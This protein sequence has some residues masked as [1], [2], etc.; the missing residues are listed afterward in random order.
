MMLAVVIDM[1]L[2]PEWIPLFEQAGW[3][4]IHWSAV[5]DPAADDK[6]IMAWAAANKHVIFTHDLDFSTALALT[7]A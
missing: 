6:V 5:G 1:N 3:S 4:A 2:S 7:R